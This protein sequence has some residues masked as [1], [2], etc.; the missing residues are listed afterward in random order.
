MPL[1]EFDHVVKRYADITVLPDF[2]LTIAPREFTVIL[3]PPGSGK[4]TILRLL[5]GAERVDGGC[6]R[7]DGVDADPLPA[8][9]RGCALVAQG[10][11]LY[12]NLTVGQ[13]IEHQLK[14]ARIRA[15]ER[16]RMVADLARTLQ[17]EGLLP[18]RPEYLTIGERLR[19]AIARASARQPR[20]LLFDEPWSDLETTQK[21]ELQ[22][23]LASLRYRLEATLLL[24]TRDQAATMALADRVVVINRGEIEQVGSPRQIFGSPTSPFVAGYIGQP[25]MNLLIVGCSQEGM[26][27]RGKPDVRLPDAVARTIVVRQTGAASEDFLLGVRPEKIQ[28]GGDQGLGARVLRTE[29][30]DGQRIVHLDLNGQH[31]AA[32]TTPEVHFLPGTKINVTLPPEACHVFL[33]PGAEKSST[34]PLLQ[35][36]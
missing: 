16:E 4:S 29:T 23:E 1:I 17:L 22:Y 26:R 27:L 24:V 31:L 8:P 12:P 20:V 7:I 33:P 6:L 28:L 35:M 11:A 3:G 21:M 32:V 18:L 14:R 15:P 36:A 9:E 2:S 13:N 30:L 19:V 10:D 5:S 34:A 25:P